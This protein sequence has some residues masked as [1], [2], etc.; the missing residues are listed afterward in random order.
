MGDYWVQKTKL[1]NSDIEEFTLS[2]FRQSVEG[3]TQVTASNTDRRFYSIG[4]Q[5][6][7]GGI[8][9][10]DPSNIQLHTDGIW[11][12]PKADLNGFCSDFYAGHFM[13]GA[14][15]QCTRE[16]DLSADST[17]CEIILNSQ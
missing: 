15:N 5:M 6:K 17:D 1:E 11:S 16:V 2:A 12:I 8:V 3:Q 7:A 10:G 4:D 9:G 13:Q 14:N